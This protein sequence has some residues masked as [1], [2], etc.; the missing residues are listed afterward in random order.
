MSVT[1]ERPDGVVHIVFHPWDPFG[2]TAHWEAPFG[3]EDAPHDRFESRDLVTMLAWA[4]TSQFF[5]SP[6]SKTSGQVRQS[7]TPVRQR[8]SL[9]S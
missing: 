2:W 8:S 9:V 6:N 3:A 5:Q 4:T 7:I 1:I